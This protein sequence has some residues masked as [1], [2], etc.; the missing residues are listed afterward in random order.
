MGVDHPSAEIIHELPHRL[1]MFGGH[2]EQFGCFVQG[3]FEAAEPFLAGGFVDD[4]WEVAGSH[5]WWAVALLEE[6]RA[7]EEED[8]HGGVLFGGDFAVFFA[9]GEHVGDG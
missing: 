3:I 7:A 6:V 8:E 5:H 1:D 4:E 9:L 2:V